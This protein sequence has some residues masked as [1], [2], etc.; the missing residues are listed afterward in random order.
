MKAIITGTV[1]TAYQSKSIGS[2]GIPIKSNADGSITAYIEFDS[3]ADAKKHLVKVANKL[4]DDPKELREALKDI[5]KGYL[6]YDAAT[7]YI[8][9]P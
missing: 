7:V 4:F 9:K 3:I 6:S 1:P 5:K 8:E 2:F